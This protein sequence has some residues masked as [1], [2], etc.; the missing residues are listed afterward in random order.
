MKR[1]HLIF[2]DPLNLLHATVCR[3]SRKRG[4]AKGQVFHVDFVGR[5]GRQTP[6]VVRLA[7]D[8]R[9]HILPRLCRSQVARGYNIQGRKSRNS[10]RLLRYVPSDISKKIKL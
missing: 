1:G 5:P 4:C 7:H 10:H 6:R 9:Q 3:G 2:N 8:W